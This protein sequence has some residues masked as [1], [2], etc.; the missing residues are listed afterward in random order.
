M[1]KNLHMKILNLKRPPYAIEAFYEYLVLKITTYVK[2]KFAHKTLARDK[3]KRIH[4]STDPTKVNHLDFLNFGF[5]QIP[6]HHENNCADVD[7][8]INYLNV[9]TADDLQDKKDL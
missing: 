3:G 7:P 6:G 2:G 1:K 8:D 9:A 4:N 5:R